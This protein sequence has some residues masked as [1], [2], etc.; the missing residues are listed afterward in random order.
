VV[1][2]GGF[3]GIGERQVTI[4]LDRLRMEGDRLVSELTKDQVQSMR[5]YDRAG[6]EAYDRTRP[7]GG[8]L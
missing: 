3:L 5:A 6:Y 1:G 7:L 8:T 2:V 4:P